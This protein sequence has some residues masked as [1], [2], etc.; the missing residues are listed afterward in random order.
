[1]GEWLERLLLERSG[2]GEW[3]LAALALVLG[4]ACVVAV[5]CSGCGGAPQTIRSAVHAG[6]IVLVEVDRVAAEQYRERAEAALES[7]ASLAE[8]R[9][10]MAPM[11][12]L[13]GALQSAAAA[14][15]VSEALVSAWDEGAEG[16]WSEVM[17]HLMAAY[18]AVLRRLR[19][20]GIEP[21]ENIFR[22]L[23]GIFTRPGEG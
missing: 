6:A 15:E 18:E 2:S 14:L 23:G 8:Y 21:P 22:F 11:D 19:A 9:E 5:M 7:S 12:E 16:R 10:R 4:V 3:R 13:Q 17:H 1:M 20:A